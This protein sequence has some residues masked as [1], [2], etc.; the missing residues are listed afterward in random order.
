[1]NPNR[2]E[3]DFLNRTQLVGIVVL[4]VASGLSG[5]TYEVL[6]TRNLALVLGSS[7]SATSTVLAVFLG[8]LCL[9]SVCIARRRRAINRPLRLYAILEVFIGLYAACIPWL[10]SGGHWMQDLFYDRLVDS[11]W[12]TMFLNIVVAAVVLIPPTMAMGATLPILS[13]ACATD[14]PRTATRVGLLYGFNTLGAVAGVILTGFVL[15]RRF[16]ADGTLHLAVAIN[17]VVGCLAFVMDSRFVR[18]VKQTKST[19]SVASNIT[20]VNA[21]N[22]DRSRR[23]MEWAVL[24]SGAGALAGE[25]LW[26]R[27]LT[28]TLHSTVYAFSG[29]L[30]AFLLG[31]ALGGAAGASVLS[32]LRRPMTAFAVLLILAA[33][34]NGMSYLLFFHLPEWQVQLSRGVDDAF[35]ILCMRLIPAAGLVFF[36]AVF[37][38][39]LFPLAIAA[40]SPT[41]SD[42]RR[43]VGRLYAFNT[44]GTIFGSLLTGF[45][46]IPVMTIENTWLI[47]VV[48]QIALAV[49]VLAAQPDKSTRDVSGASIAGVMVVAA[50]L[51]LRP[52]WSAHVG[53]RFMSPG[54]VATGTN[55]GWDEWTGMSR[56]TSR[57]VAWAEGR[58]VTVTVVQTHGR[59][60]RLRSNGMSE[61]YVPI[62]PRNGRFDRATSALGLLPIM[63]H[64][65][66]QTVC[67]VGLGGG[68]TLQ[69]VL[70]SNVRSVV[71]I[72]LIP[73]VVRMVRT[74]LFPAGGRQASPLDDPRVR[75]VVNDARYVLEYGHQTYDVIIAQPSHPWLAGS[76]GV[77]TREFLQIVSRRLDPRGV[78]CQWFPIDRLNVESIA[79]FLAT[80]RSV[81]TH[82]QVFEIDD[83][84]VL[85]ASNQPLRLNLE[86]GHQRLSHGQLAEQ[87]ERLNWS[88]FDLFSGYVMSE[89]G[90][91]AL[92]DALPARV[93]TDQNAYWETTLPIA[94]EAA[95]IRGERGISM[96]DSFA[97][98]VEDFDALF[99]PEPV[100]T[101]VAIDAL[102]TRIVQ[103][104]F[105]DAA[106]LVRAGC[107]KPV[108]FLSPFL[109]ALA[110][111]TSG[112]HPNQV[113]SQLRREFPANPLGHQIAAYAALRSEAPSLALEII[114]EARIHVPPHPTP[115]LVDLERLALFL[116]NPTAEN[117]RVLDQ[118]VN[119]LDPFVRHLRHKFL[120]RFHAT[121][122]DGDR[123]W[124]ACHLQR[125]LE[126]VA[127]DLAS[128][129]TL[130]TL[131]LEDARSCPD[132]ARRWSWALDAVA[133]GLEFQLRWGRLSPAQ[134]LSLRQIADA[135]LRLAPPLALDAKVSPLDLK[136]ARSYII[137][138]RNRIPESD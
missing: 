45:L 31:L 47:V 64:Q 103:T 77:F 19:T 4:F 89:R 122:I 17:I 49:W 117:R 38:G 12:L 53:G 86:D 130:S 3:P 16:G 43:Q 24:L 2:T 108:S 11:A 102:G 40:H 81:F 59:F 70:A 61:S 98:Y 90:M 75:L 35:T 76:S 58:D 136:L 13:E 100:T 115:A 6:W 110:D 94:R 37:I 132:A 126:M 20:Q 34:A 85:T 107:M 32:R 44:V 51:F 54:V 28:L 99:L 124:A 41:R 33:G 74:V 14:D 83:Q 91:D 113:V 56:L 48:G 105:A 5:L 114:T 131:L 95:L 66:A 123:D 68:V 121:S 129:Q 80:A 111:R 127:N 15:L 84:L 10:L 30:A 116:Q 118:D 87:M 18:S 93:N 7:T 27:M 52:S 92:L 133:S 135:W 106:R 25:V 78:F 36:P 88:P 128:V 42:A 101:A 79:S 39:A 62:D 109:D 26:F 29:M 63:F 50:F 82:L 69:S 72:E 120:G 22:L 21:V 97:D 137:S 125:H 55:V 57:P 1:M 67:I 71:C 73:E 65:N 134:S 8:G 9:G 112:V 23:V 138:Q 96:Q 46:L 119:R 104:Q 60:L